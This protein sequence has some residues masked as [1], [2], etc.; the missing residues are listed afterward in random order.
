MKSKT[1]VW[2]KAEKSIDKIE[3]QLNGL[4]ETVDFKF[5]T[6][7]QSTVKGKMIVTL[8]FEDKPGKIRARVFKDQKHSSIDDKVNEFL[9]GKQM[10]FVTQTYIGS[11]VYTIL[12]YVEK[13]VKDAPPANQ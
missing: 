10:K 1:L 8:F 13:E 11:N 2:T 12:Y 9:I 4:L 5:A 7:N 6:Q 3:G